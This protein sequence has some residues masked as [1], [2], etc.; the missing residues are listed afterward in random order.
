M[1]HTVTSYIDH[2]YFNEAQMESFDADNLPDLTQYPRISLDP[3]TAYRFRLAALNSCGRGEWGE[4]CPILNFIFFFRDLHHEGF[5]FRYPVLKRVFPGFLVLR[6]PL[7]YQK[8]LKRG[9]T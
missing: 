5:I 6:R 2:K 9:P 1:S 7:R 4:V 3:G 8:I